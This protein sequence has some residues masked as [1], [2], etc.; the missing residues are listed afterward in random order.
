MKKIQ[1][2]V[3]CALLIASGMS[4]ANE[5]TDNEDAKS[6]PL[7]Q[8][9]IFAEVFSRIKKDYVEEV[10]DTE[11]LEHAIQ[12]M[13][14]GLDPH[15]VYL[16]KDDFQDLREGTEGQFGGLGMEVGMKDGF[17]KVIA[18]IDDTPA[19]KAGIKAGDLIVRIDGQTVKG[20]SLDE[21]IGLLRGEPGSKVLLHI[22]REAS[23]GP[24]EVSVERAIIKTASVKSRLLEGAYGYV[25]L[26]QFQSRAGND[27]RKA[28]DKLIK[29]ADEPLKG[30]VLDLR[31]NPGGVLTEAVEVSD[32]F[33]EHGLVVYT[34]GRNDDSR[35]SFEAK[36]GDMIKG[37][38]LVVL[39]NDGSASASEIV[40]GALQ[41]HSRAII[42]GQK[43]FGKG[44]VQTIVNVN[45]RVGI[46]LTTARYFTPNGS[47]IQAE[48]IEPDIVLQK[49]ELKDSEDKGVSLSE[50]NLTGHLDNPDA[51]EDDAEGKDKTSL[52]KK[53]YALFEALNLLKGLAVLR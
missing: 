12:G 8:L 49:L 31:N 36:P 13:L 38:P 42:M 33:L 26:S 4:Y 27:V 39:V 43:T 2:S 25:R 15:S 53:D 3:L 24:F 18:P 5:T 32:I 30:L 21:A 11:L 29:E 34:E 22:V 44:S 46:K 9:K 40:A 6:L 47:S 50:A 20:M 52:A 41:D 14:S 1:I 16:N 28:V 19:K 51:H 7:E 23:D 35:V 10:D 45:E 17:V 48:G 37:A